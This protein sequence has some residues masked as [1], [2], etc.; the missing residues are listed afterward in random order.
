MITD[1][2]LTARPKIAVNQQI[3]D[4]LVKHGASR[5]NEISQGIGGDDYGKR[6]L[7]SVISGK[8][9]AMA[10]SGILLREKRRLCSYWSI[11]HDREDGH[12]KERR[13]E[14]AYLAK[15]NA[16][17]MVQAVQIVAPEMR[18]EVLSELYHRMNTGRYKSSEIGKALEHA[19]KA[20]RKQIRGGWKEDM[21]IDGA[22][23]EDGFKLL[24]IA[25]DDDKSFDELWAVER[26]VDQIREA[27]GNG[28][29]FDQY[30]HLFDTSGTS[31]LRHAVK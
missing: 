20:V 22:L 18:G 16:E 9:Q 17:R 8:C 12:R 27:I 28:Y 15:L 2:S 10:K 3:R 4:F 13:K 11:N 21:S 26:R 19:M 5:A 25:I 30:Q 7:V 31:W 14:G 23:T 24:D 29:W 6:M 1:A